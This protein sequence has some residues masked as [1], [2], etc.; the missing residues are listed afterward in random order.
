M[1]SGSLLVSSVVYWSEHPGGSLVPDRV[2]PGGR[3]R[4]YLGRP[5][6]IPAARC[7]TCRLCVIP[8]AGSC[9]HQLVDGWAFPQAALRWVAGD[10]EFVPAFL[11]PFTGKGRNGVVAETLFAP[12][13]TFSTAGTRRRAQRCRACGAL[14]V[15]YADGS[16]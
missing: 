16:R 9:A 1:G 8:G 13:L 2:L 7:V 4:T 10:R 15:K 12:G 5:A 11:F 14:I 3:V 6:A